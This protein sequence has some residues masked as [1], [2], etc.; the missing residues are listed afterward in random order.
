MRTAP[1][2]VPASGVAAAVAPAPAVAVG[3]RLALPAPVFQAR[4]SGKPKTLSLPR[5]RETVGARAGLEAAS[6]SASRLFDGTGSPGPA[7]LPVAVAKP[8]TAA[9]AIRSTLPE[10]QEWLDSVVGELRRSRSAR[11][12]LRRVEALARERGRPVPVEVTDVR[13]LAGEFSLDTEVV[14]LKSALKKKDLGD[15]GSVLIHELLHAAQQ[16]EGVPSDLFELELEA[17]MLD[18]RVALELGGEYGASP[19][20]RK[21]ER[22]FRKGVGPL[23]D[24][25]LGGL[26]KND[27]SVLTLGVGG[28]ERE[29]RKRESN[30]RARLLRLEARIAKRRETVAALRGLGHPAARVRAYEAEELAKLERKLAEERSL[31]AWHARDLAIL[32]DPAGRARVRR[33]ARRVLAYARRTHRRYSATM[34]TSPRAWRATLLAGGGSSERRSD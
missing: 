8:E 3:A 30:T 23:M 19:W 16:A 4:L 10:D 20:D 13:P 28:L 7:A 5:A 22:H 2:L 17:Y 29:L 18:I 24:F 33:Y 1:V 12:V 27:V 9:A 11:A 26:Y 31:S 15:A 21:V 34:S 25:L 14:R 32:A 6:L